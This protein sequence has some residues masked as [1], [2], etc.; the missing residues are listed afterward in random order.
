[1]SVFEYGDDIGGE[2][3][4]KD[5]ADRGKN[6]CEELT[7]FGDT[8]DVGTDS[9]DVHEGPVKGVPIGGHLR[10]GV[11]LYKV[12]HDTAEVDG[13]EEEGYIGGKKTGDAV[14]T[15]P[16]ENDGY[17]VYAPNDGDDAEKY[18]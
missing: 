3:W 13:G 8:V 2:D 1:M 17:S 5:H 16:A 18:P 9:C 10:V 15:E 4:E 6:Y 14:A 11:M 12:E 7:D